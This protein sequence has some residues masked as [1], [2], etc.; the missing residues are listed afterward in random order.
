MKKTL[1]FLF[2]LS[3]GAGTMAI[4][5]PV[6]CA[7]NFI[8]TEKIA[9]VKAGSVSTA[10]ASWWGFNADDATE[11]L[12]QAI[13]S[14][15][16]K[17]VI[18]NVGSPWIINKPITLAS[19]QE[20]I[21]DKDVLVLAKKGSFKGVNDCLFIGKNIKN[22]T[23]SGHPGATLQMQRADYTDPNL[24]KRSEWRH[25]ISY[26]D[27]E[28]IVIRGFTVRDTGGDGLYLG[29]SPTG[30]NKNV[31]V[32]DMVFD[33]NHRL[34]LA[35]ISAEDLLIRRSK[36]Q[37]TKGTNPQGGIDFEPNYPG[38]RLVNCVVEDSTFTDNNAGGIHIY[39]VN[40][41]D[42]S[43]PI[44]L[45]FKNCY[46]EGNG[47]GVTSTTTNIKHF[48]NAVK[49]TI[50]FENCRFIENRI[51]LRNLFT[52]TTEYLF[53]NCIVDGRESGAAFN[54]PIDTTI[55]NADFGGIT[56]DNTIVKGKSQAPL[57][58]PARGIAT[59][60]EKIQGTLYKENNGSKQLFD[61][62]EY[63]K[64]GNDHWKRINAQKPGFLNLDG[65]SLPLSDA[66]R[67]GNRDFFLQGKFEFI[68]YA[69]KGD[70]ITLKARA[71]QVYK[72]KV[73]LELIS[74]NGK[75][76]KEIDIKLDGK[77]VPITFTADQTGF[78]RLIRKAH[79]SQYVDVHSSHRGNALV[80][81]PDLVFLKPQ[82]RLYFQV[83]KGVKDFNI[84]IST[85]AG[86]KVTLFDQNNKPVE[87]KEDVRSQHLFSG[88]RKDDSTS[89]I[90]SLGVEDAKWLF[91][92]NMYK[93]L[94]PLVSTNP[95]TLLLAE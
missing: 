43:L 67:K 22:S 35:V 72:Q 50:T 24:Y 49:G 80:V 33:S 25:G 40:L 7:D 91:T 55:K 44:S 68:Q 1:S 6:A 15:V 2:A 41:N 36:F 81:Q 74:P 14:G 38:Q 17:L 5:I 27:S 62:E 65:L 52:Q 73:I 31:L 23:L 4:N 92:I 19:N 8:N 71:K 70:S 53:K 51:S 59:I 90:W 63:K 82:G 61:L 11:A 21:F 93:P 89:Q 12:Q 75:I 9:A 30:Y 79:K 18:D 88:H 16:S 42:S 94:I 45:N 29:A 46:I 39:A 20:I 34:G 76:L 87:Q 64:K 3:V 37:N 77:E 13:N 95:D 66:P 83:P 56:F 10:Q 69:E 57:S 26:I 47:L 78:Y 32:E 60:S 85:D 84:G 48:E 58:S 28:N 54:V 86:A